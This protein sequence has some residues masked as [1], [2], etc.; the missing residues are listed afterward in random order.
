MLL[1]L[2]FVLIFSF[3]IGLSSNEQSADIVCEQSVLALQADPRYAQSDEQGKS[4]SH[5]SD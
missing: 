3:F 5:V 1:I 2:C 4:V